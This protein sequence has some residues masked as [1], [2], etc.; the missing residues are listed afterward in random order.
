MSPAAA[1][2]TNRESANEVLHTHP[3]I[4]SA[5]PSPRHIEVHALVHATGRRQ[6]VAKSDAAL[7]PCGG[8][9]LESWAMGGDLGHALGVTSS[10][11]RAPVRTR[12]RGRPG[13]GLRRRLDVALFSRDPRPQM[14]VLLAT[15]GRREAELSGRKNSGDDEGRRPR[16]ESCEQWV[17]PPAGVRCPS[18]A[19][20]HPTTPHHDWQAYLRAP[21][22]RRQEG[23]TS[24]RTKRGLVPWPL[25]P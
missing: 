13:K 23:C 8:A 9:V 11:H 17:R 6:R 5:S 10:P 20:S 21:R 19:D 24:H 7:Q 16:S 18:G 2:R 12:C 22:L 15:R 4:R 14:L 25:V 1:Q 3:T